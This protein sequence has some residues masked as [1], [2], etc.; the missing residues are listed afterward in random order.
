M[1][2]TDSPEL[3]VPEPAAVP[4]DAPVSAPSAYRNRLNPWCVVR[5]SSEPQSV[6]VARF[7]RRPE[8]EAHLRVLQAQVKGEFAIIFANQ[9][10]PE[11]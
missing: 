3:T 10:Q 2:T 9:P 8:A 11:S 7:R 1:I 4:A 6:T 5:L